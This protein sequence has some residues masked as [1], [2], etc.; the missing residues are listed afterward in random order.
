VITISGKNVG[1]KLKKLRLA[2]GETQEELAKVLGVS[3][4]I[5]SMYELGERN[6]SDQM[7]RKYAEHFNR[8]VGFLFFKD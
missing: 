5:I 3:K 7:K 8:T 2:K 4:A 6:P 1:E